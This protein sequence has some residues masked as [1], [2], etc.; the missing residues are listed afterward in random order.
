MPNPRNR[1]RRLKLFAPLFILA[2]VLA[3]GSV[4]QVWYTATLA[5]TQI[6]NQPVAAHLAL[7]GAQIA[8]MVATPLS[9]TSALT[10]LSTTSTNPTVG[11]MFGFIDPVAYVMAAAILL[12][13]GVAITSLLASGVGLIAAF[14]AWTQLS[15]MRV[16]FE[17][18]LT[19]GGFTLARGPGQERIWLALTL[20]MGFGLLA[21]IQVAL[22]RHAQRVA[23]NEPGIMTSLLAGLGQRLGTV[24]H[25]AQRQNE[26]HT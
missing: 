10:G 7:T 15:A 21:V 4:H 8:K 13:L 6:Q 14:F 1:A 23:N 25:E 3:Y 9:P 24:V 16:Q 19:T 22:V 5:P 26:H 2:L 17:N 18:P 12:A 11:T 20:T